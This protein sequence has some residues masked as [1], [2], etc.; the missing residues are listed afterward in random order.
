MLPEGTTLQKFSPLG[1]MSGTMLL[2]ARIAIGQKQYSGMFLMKQMPADSSVRILYLSEVGLS[3]M[4]LTYKEDE[5]EMNKIQ[6]FL[7]RPLLI[8]VIQD[9]L[10]TLLLDLP[11]VVPS[12]V[13]SEAAAS[14]EQMKFKHKSQK[15]RYYYSGNPVPYRIDRKKGWFGKTVYCIEGTDPFRAGIT[16]RG[17]QLRIDLQQLER[18]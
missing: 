15:Y 13:H 7:D 3:L 1:N 6:D 10:R 18:D 12:S 17:I 9:D 11:E 8:K 2:K 4:D 5:F 14:P 16:H